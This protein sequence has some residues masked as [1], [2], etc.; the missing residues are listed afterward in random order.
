[1]NHS[2]HSHSQYITGVSALTNHSIQPCHLT[3]LSTVPPCP[4]RQQ[5]ASGM[6]RPN[7]LPFRDKESKTGKTE[8][9]AKTFVFLHI[10]LRISN[11]QLQ[12]ITPSWSSSCQPSCCKNHHAS[13]RC[14]SFGFFVFFHARFIGVLWRL[15]FVSYPFNFAFS[16]DT[17]TAFSNG[18]K[19]SQLQ[20]NPYVLFCCGAYII[21]YPIQSAHILPFSDRSLQVL[22]GSHQSPTCMPWLWNQTESPKVRKYHESMNIPTKPTCTTLP[23]GV[24]SLV[25]LSFLP[26]SNCCPGHLL[27]ME[28]SGH[29]LYAVPPCTF[30]HPNMPCFTDPYVLSQKPIAKLTQALISADL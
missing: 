4:S 16:L 5:E 20:R 13:R 28:Q 6:R 2:N 30:Q 23:C 3:Y 19:M 9:N 8:S 17:F 7:S 22:D 25:T 12:R 26:T 15:K 11:P 24:L 29:Y 18:L 14:Q 10:S 21:Q 1:M 27:C